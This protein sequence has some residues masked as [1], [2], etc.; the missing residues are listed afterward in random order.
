MILP[1][2]QDLAKNTCIGFT[3]IVPALQLYV[4]SIVLTGLLYNDLLLKGKVFPY[5]LP[6]VGPAADPGVQ[7]VSPQVT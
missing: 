1:G 4:F 3:A 7:A 5:S 2:L 6:S